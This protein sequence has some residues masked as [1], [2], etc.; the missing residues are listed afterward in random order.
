LVRYSVAKTQSVSMITIKIPRTLLQWVDSANVG[1]SRS[2]KVRALLVYA[3]SSLHK[4][5]NNKLD[6][7]FN[8]ANMGNSNTDSYI[9]RSVLIPAPI[10]EAAKK[11][12]EDGFFMSYTEALRVFSLIGAVKLIEQV[13]TC[14]GE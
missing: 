11:L 10:D 6:I 9:R 2:E 14:D 3:L 5:N 7:D 1:K 4:L 12:V 13:Y 8:I